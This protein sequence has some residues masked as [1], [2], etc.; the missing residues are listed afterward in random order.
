[1]PHS[2]VR[3]TRSACVS[4]LLSVAGSLTLACEASAQPIHALTLKST[5]TV[6]PQQPSTK[7]DVWASFE[8][9]F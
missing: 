8:P 2:S 1:M 4:I 7:I 3:P 6:S 9:Q 5:G